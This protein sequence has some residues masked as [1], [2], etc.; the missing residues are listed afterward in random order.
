VLHADRLE[1]IGI[2]M[3]DR[4]VIPLADIASLSEVRWFNGERL[5]WKRGFV[6][7]LK[8]G[9]R[10]GVAVPEPFGRRWRACLSGGSLPELSETKSENV[11][12]APRFSRAAIAGAC[13]IPFFFASAAFLVFEPH[14][15]PFPY[16]YNLPAALAILLSLS[17]CFGTTILGWISVSQIRHSAGKLYGMWLAVLDGLLFPLLAVD[18]LITVVAVIVG[19][20]IMP[21]VHDRIFDSFQ[22]GFTRTRTGPVLPVMAGFALL[23][24]AVD[25]LIC[26]AIW[27]AVKKP[28]GSAREATSAP[29]TPHPGKRGPLALVWAAL[30]VGIL[31]MAIC[32][33][34]AGQ[35]DRDASRPQYVDDNRQGLRGGQR[36]SCCLRRSSPVSP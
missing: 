23:L 29:A 12:S 26:H 14:H 5:W 8:D 2:A 4:L 32:D 36:D 9:R 11:E 7:D 1:L 18:G 19:K 31:V 35:A 30:L 21:G 16:N 13:W 17:G 28:Q 15:I 25:F 10:V 6:L 24:M 27:R 33:L 3:I 20:S 34:L 22:A